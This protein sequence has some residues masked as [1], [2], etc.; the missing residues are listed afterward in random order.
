MTIKINYSLPNIEPMFFEKLKME[1]DETN[2][3]ATVAK[4][5]IGRDILRFSKIWIAERLRTTFEINDVDVIDITSI[6]FL[7]E[8]EPHIKN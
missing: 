6:K 8:D 1:Y 5:P 4:I 2:T 7:S 3:L